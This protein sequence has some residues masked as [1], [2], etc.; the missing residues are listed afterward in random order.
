MQEI[1]KR[2]LNLCEVAVYLGV[3]Y[4][5]AKNFCEKIG[6]KRKLDRRCLYDLAVIDKY[7]ENQAAG[8]SKK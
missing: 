2:Y 4:V 6:A 3:S 7:F 5:T 8:Q 1:K